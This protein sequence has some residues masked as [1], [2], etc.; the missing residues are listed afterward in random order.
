LSR[1]S[2]L[3]RIVDRIIREAFNLRRKR[4]DGK[5]LTELSQAMDVEGI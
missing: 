3:V 5:P 1:I 4:R 2:Q